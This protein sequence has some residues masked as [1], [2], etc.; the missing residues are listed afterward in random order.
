M[1]KDTILAVMGVECQD[2][3]LE[4]LLDHARKSDA[5]VAMIVIG[6]S[7]QIP[8][9][10]F[11]AMPYGSMELS[12]KWKSDYS[13]GNAAVTERAEQLETLLSDA[14]VSGDIQVAYDEAASLGPAVARRAKICDLVFI[15][16]DLRANMDVFNHVVQGA[17]FG[18]PAGVVLNLIPAAAEIDLRNVFVAWNTSL[19]AS[20]AV[21]A[22]LPVLVAADSVEIACFDPVMKEYRD[23]QN[24]GSDVAKWLSHKGCTVSVEQI[25]SGGLEIGQCILDRAAEFGADLIVMGAYG[26]ARMRQAVFGG[27]TRSLVEQARFPVLLAH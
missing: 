17:L 23:G 25:P 22:A 10:T 6:E 9:G 4:R 2:S 24:P 26:H 3:H 20:R 13:A 5:H 27:T 1:N 11:A 7:P 12:D 19:P 14:G 16:N 18:A 15:S 8:M 21:H